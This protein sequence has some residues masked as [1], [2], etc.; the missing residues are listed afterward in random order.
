MENHE[1]LRSAV[2]FLLA[3]VI[4]VPLTRRFRLGAVL[5]YLLAGVAIGPSVLGLIS[6]T[7]G[8]CCRWSPARRPWAAS[9]TCCSA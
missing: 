3:T 9:V 5:G 7:E 2:V 4:A 6:D 1:F 8:A